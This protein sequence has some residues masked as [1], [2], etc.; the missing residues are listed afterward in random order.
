MYFSDFFGVRKSALNKYGAFDISLLADLPLFVDPFLLFNSKKPKYRALHD[1]MIEYLRFLKEKSTSDQ[2]LEGGYSQL[3]TCFL[4]S[5][6]IGSAFQQRA[7]TD[8]AWVE[9]SPKRS[10]R[11]WAK[12]SV[13]SGART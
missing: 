13:R 6:R 9:V 7:I 12:S 10:T 3:G 1:R 4:R 8:T 11:I 5:S 2:G